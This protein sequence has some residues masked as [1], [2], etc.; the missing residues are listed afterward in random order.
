LVLILG[1]VGIGLGN[2]SN[3]QS[4]R[5]NLCTMPDVPKEPPEPN[6]AA[7]EAQLRGIVASAM[8]AIISVDETQRIVLFNAAAERMFGYAAYEL[9]C[10]MRQPNGCLGT[11]PGKP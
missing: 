5:K 6:L 7:G 11:P 9:S 10:L 3:L 8:D 1:L 2:A 4:W